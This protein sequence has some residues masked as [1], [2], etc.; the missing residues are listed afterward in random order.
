MCEYV[1][2]LQ[3]DDEARVRIAT[4]EEIP[5]A[6]ESDSLD[7]LIE[8]VKIATP[9]LLKLNRVQ[10]DASSIQLKFNAVRVERIDL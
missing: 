4:N 2:D 3:W 9:E 5:I 7:V 6:L 8:R 10:H 1:I